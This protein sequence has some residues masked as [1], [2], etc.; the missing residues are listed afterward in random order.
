[1]SS[2]GSQMRKRF[3]QL[4]KAGENVPKIISYVAT[5]GTQAAVNKATEMTP[6][7]NAPIAGVNMRSGQMAQAWQNDSQITPTVSGN[8]YT[9]ILANGQEYA[10][11]VNMGHRVDKHF[12]PGLYVDGGMLNRDLTGRAKGLVVGTQTTYVPGIQMTEKA[13]GKYRTTVRK[14]LDKR[15]REAFK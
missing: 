4:R 11:Y 8:T 14:E 3:E 12:V 2:F 7:H 9:T 1:M 6:P 5:E 10:S 15:V 13:V